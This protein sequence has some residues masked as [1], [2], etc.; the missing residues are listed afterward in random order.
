MANNVI[1]GNDLMLFVGGKAIAGAKSCKITVN[2]STLDVSSKDSG[3]WAE[4]MGGQLSF[5]ASSENLFV[6]TEFKDLFNKLI[7]REK[8]TISFGYVLNREDNGVPG[9][10]WNMS[11]TS[12]YTGDAII[13]SLDANASNGDIASFSINLEGTGPLIAL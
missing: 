11:D 7:A 9:G 10:G 2:A 4:K 6:L 12:T 8:I 1:L 5:N 13:T 3:I